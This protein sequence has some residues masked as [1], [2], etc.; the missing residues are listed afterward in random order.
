M[1]NFYLTFE[2]DFKSKKGHV[3][4]LPGRDQFAQDLVYPFWNIIN[5]FPISIIT[6]QSKT[7]YYPVPNGL[8]NQNHSLKGLKQT[9]KELTEIIN[10]LNLSNISLWG[11]SAGGVVAFELFNKIK[12]L[13]GLYMCCSCCLK[14]DD[15]AE[16]ENNSPIYFR[17]SKEDTIFKYHER[18]HPTLIKLQSNNYKLNTMCVE[19]DNHSICKK[20]FDFTEKFLIEIYDNIKK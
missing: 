9:T 19:N 20:D 10:K 6:I 4:F 11:Y 2:K 13:I 12:N 5:K 8:N 17:Y 15:M 3:I 7:N 1:K 18:I 14:P 16:A